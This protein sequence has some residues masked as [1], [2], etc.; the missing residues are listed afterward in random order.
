LGLP[1][2]AKIEQSQIG[3]NA[4]CDAISKGWDGMELTVPKGD[5]QRFYLMADV[6]FNC[7]ENRV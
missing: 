3:M 5:S 7:N 1:A 6:H 2:L 4:R